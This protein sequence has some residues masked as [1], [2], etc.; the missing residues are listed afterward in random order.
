MNDK[1][2][3]Y[4]PNYSYLNHNIALGKSKD[5]YPIIERVINAELYPLCP[6]DNVD[7]KQ[8]ELKD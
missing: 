2:L 4:D 6:N 5:G 1:K 3:N 7:F 8:M